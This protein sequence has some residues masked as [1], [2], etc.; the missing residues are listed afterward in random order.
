MQIEKFVDAVRKMMDFIHPS[1]W[2][3]RDA[4]RLAHRTLNI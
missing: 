3:W 1:G 2:F 4:L